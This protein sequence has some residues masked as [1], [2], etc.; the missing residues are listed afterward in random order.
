MGINYL[1]EVKINGITKDTIKYKYDFDQEDNEV[2]LIWDENLNSCECMFWKC[3]DITEINLTNFDTS[4]ITSMKRFFFYCSSLISLDLS[5]FDTSQVTDMECMFCECV[6]LTS[7]DL[8][9]F[10]TSK[11]TT[12]LQ[13]FDNCANI[14]VINL[15]NFDESNLNNANYMF[16]KLPSNAVVCVKDITIQ[17]KII[18]ALDNKKNA[19][20]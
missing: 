6:L 15:N 19:M 16:F 20:L 1:K 14:E 17:S 9:N 13:M 7:L 12:T 5:K 10:N 4:K 18:S 3:S 11:V 8:S 2:E